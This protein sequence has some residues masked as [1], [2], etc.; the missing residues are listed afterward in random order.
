MLATAPTLPMPCNHP[1]LPLQAITGAPRSA[2]SEECLARSPQ[3]GSWQAQWQ[4]SPKT[5]Q[6]GG[7]LSVDF[8]ATA[9]LQP[10]L[11]NQAGPSQSGAP[12][13]DRKQAQHW[14][15]TKHMI[16]GRPGRLSLDTPQSLPRVSWDARQTDQLPIGTTHIALPVRWSDAISQTL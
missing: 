10:S 16:C 14:N 3:L 13:C 15:S 7:K 11:V 12:V 6:H 4:K 2:H 8:T 9:R 5:V 1:L